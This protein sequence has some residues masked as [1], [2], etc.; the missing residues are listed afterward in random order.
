MSYSFN[1]YHEA[2]KRT[3]DMRDTD[4]AKR[5]MTAALG[6]AGEAGE[7]AQVIQLIVKH[8]SES[9]DVGDEAIDELWYVMFLC[10][11]YGISVDDI[12]GGFSDMDE[13]QKECVH[14]KKYLIDMSFAL[15]MVASQVADLV[16][17]ECAHNHAPD[18]DALTYY[19]EEIVFWIAAILAKRDILFSEAAKANVEKLRL[20][21]PEGFSSEAS[22]NRTN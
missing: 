20:R 5:K 11:L 4:T 15:M 12:S 1:E 13:F 14:A 17:K 21:Y 10:H 16:K 19:L 8:K 3:M 7:I 6:L 2:S 9:F 18:V 22:I